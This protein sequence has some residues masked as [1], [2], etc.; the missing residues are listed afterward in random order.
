MQ[1]LVVLADSHG[2]VVTRDMLFRRCW[3][4]PSVGDDSLNRAI[5][6]VRRIA[7]GVSAGS[8]EVETVPRTGYRL[9]E[10]EAAAAPRPPGSPRHRSRVSRRAAIAGALAATG[11]GAAGWWGRDRSKDR[12]FDELVRRGNDALDKADPAVDHSK[13]FLRAAELRPNDAAA[14]GMLAYALAMRAEFGPPGASEALGSAERAARDALS[15]NPREP[16]AR[17]AVS[18]LQRSMLDFA[19][20]EDRLRAILA[21]DPNNVNAMR[22]YWNLLQCVGRSGEGLALVERALA[23]SPL[24]ASNHFPRAQF[25]WI[26]GRDAEADRVI[27]RAMQY[28]PQHRWVRFARFMI[29]AFTGRP[30]AALAMLESAET[31]PQ[32][33]SPAT[34]A[35]WRTSLEALHQRT[36]KSMAAAL[37]ANVEAAKQSP[38]LTGPAVMA[39]STLGDVD[40]A[41]EALSAL[42]VVGRAEQAKNVA[43][44]GRGTGTSTAWRFAPWLFTPPVAPLRADP[45]FRTLCDEVGLTDY[46]DKRRIQPDYQLGLT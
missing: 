24:A 25:L 26:L 21:T 44:K 42:F 32:S 41:F 17:I 3:G 31:R 39:L 7:E 29:F 13:Y 38:Q 1:V 8:F 34:V 19:T 30:R 37:Q 27:D 35:L 45:R 36:P 12:E 4:S 33:F 11:I 14:H 2:A 5:A 18:M 23:V 10:N 40:A 6:G 15:L 16:N 22:Q 43:A 46:W 9:I 28:W 20:T